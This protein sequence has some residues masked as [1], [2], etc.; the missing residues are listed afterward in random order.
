MFNL[1]CAES[2][3][4]TWLMP[5]I[6]VGM[7]VLMLLFTYFPQRKKKKEAQQMMASVR[8]GKK[9]KTIGGFVGEI[10]SM[11]EKNGTMELNV[12]TK[13]SPVIVVLDKAAIYTV[14][15][16]DVPVQNQT[17]VKADEEV[18]P[19]AVTA[20]DLAQDEKEATKA[21]EKK[22]KKEAKKNQ[23]ADKNAQ[24]NVDTTT[25]NADTEQVVQDAIVEDNK[26]E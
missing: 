26:T 13:D 9:V 6:L 3:V 21:A 20:D 18:V 7:V 11:D 24:D 19:V 10:V 15:N 16:P 12:G 22:A 23:K 1:L 4:N 5:V 14:L 17:E 8:A 25:E 2:G